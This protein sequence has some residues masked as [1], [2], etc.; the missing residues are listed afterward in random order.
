M[1]GP[2]LPC[3]SSTAAASLPF[4]F[5]FLSLSFF[6]CLDLAASPRPR[7]RAPAPWSSLTGP[8][9]LRPTL[10]GPCSSEPADRTSTPPPR[11]VAADQRL[12]GG[13]VMGRQRGRPQ[14]GEA[15]RRRA[16][17]P[18]CGEPAKGRHGGEELAPR[19]STLAVG[20]GAVRRQ[21]RRR[22]PPRRPVQIQFFFCIHLKKNNFLVFYFGCTFFFLP[23]D[24]F[25]ICQNFSRKFFLSHHFVS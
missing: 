15:W 22:S 8:L 13:G 3:L 14:G 10:P 24:K 21:G 16:G 6:P 5:P 7:R 23:F 1:V 17:R 19:R 18:R 12:G 9:L 2:T 25:L 20:R 11:G 4:A